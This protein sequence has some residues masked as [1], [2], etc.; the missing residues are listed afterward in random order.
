MLQH[1]LAV[2]IASRQPKAQRAPIHHPGQP[3]PD[4]HIIIGNDEL[5]QRS[6]APLG[7][8]LYLQY[9]AEN[10]FRQGRQEQQPLSKREY[11]YRNNK[12]PSFFSAE[13]V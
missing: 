4:A 13:P 9:I 11:L 12:H 1:L 3:L 10:A 7:H 8:L 6:S 2:A 5:K